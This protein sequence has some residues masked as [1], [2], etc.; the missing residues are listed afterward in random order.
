M[1]YHQR[2]RREISS[3]ILEKYG[4]PNAVGI[5]DG[6]HIN[7]SQRPSIDGEVYWTRKGRYSLNAQIV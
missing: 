4:I 7:F 1:K 5:I 3:T 6:T 2:R